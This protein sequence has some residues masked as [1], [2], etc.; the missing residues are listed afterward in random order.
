MDLYVFC[1]HINNFTVTEEHCDDSYLSAR[2]SSCMWS[3]SSADRASPKASITQ[4]TWRLFQDPGGMSFF[5]LDRRTAEWEAWR[6][7]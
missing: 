2:V 5:S 1:L 4:D 6:L 3:M 7:T